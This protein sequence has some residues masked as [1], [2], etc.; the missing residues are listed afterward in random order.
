MAVENWESWCSIF[1]HIDCG[2]WCVVDVSWCV[3]VLIDAGPCV[4]HWCQRKRED[5]AGQIHTAIVEGDGR[6]SVTGDGDLIALTQEMKG[7]CTRAQ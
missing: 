6:Q 1:R 7:R 4:I 3:P 2:C 5:T